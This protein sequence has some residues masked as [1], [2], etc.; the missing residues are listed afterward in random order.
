MIGL[1]ICKIL[2]PGHTLTLV[3]FEPAM[4]IRRISSGAQTTLMAGW[5]VLELSHRTC[6][7]QRQNPRLSWLFVFTTCSRRISERPE[8]KGRL[9]ANL[10]K[11]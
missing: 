7:A 6:D 8:G 9:S 10:E 3:S 1:N 2:V 5:L 4:T 11:S